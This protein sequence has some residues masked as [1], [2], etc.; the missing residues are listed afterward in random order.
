MK[1]IGCG[2][3]LLVFVLVDDDLGRLRRAAI[4]IAEDAG[5]TKL[6]RDLGP[7]EDEVGAGKLLGDLARETRVGGGGRGHGGSFLVARCD[8]G[9]RLCIPCET[10]WLEHRTLFWATA[11][12][13]I[14]GSRLPD[15][16][17]EVVQI[18]TCSARDRLGGYREI[19]SNPNNL[20]SCR[21]P[22]GQGLL[23]TYV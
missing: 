16:V 17:H 23:V 2:D 15:C 1:G 11:S 12:C 14:A 6:R 13:Y 20:A 3:L 7:P 19:R 22:R 8:G 21:T 4:H 10:Q 18:T 5:T 9:V